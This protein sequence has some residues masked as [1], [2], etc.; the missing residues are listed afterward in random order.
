MTRRSIINL[1]SFVIIATGGSLLLGAKPA[2]AAFTN[3]CDKM[4]KEIDA[5]SE[6]CAKQGLGY[7]YTGSCSTTS[8]DYTLDGNCL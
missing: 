1:S 7:G 3:G 4:A 8:I 6:A 2:S 5:A